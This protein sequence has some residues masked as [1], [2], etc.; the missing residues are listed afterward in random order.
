MHAMQGREEEWM[1]WTENADQDSSRLRAKEA[2][3]EKEFKCLPT[4]EG[5]NRRH[6]A[7]CPGPAIAS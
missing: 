5:E 3:G 7:V 1:G 2:E 4:Q 6:H